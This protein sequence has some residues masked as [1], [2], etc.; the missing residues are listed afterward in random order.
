L[1]DELRHGIGC[2]LADLAV[3]PQLRFQLHLGGAKALTKL[4]TTEAVAAAEALVAQA[5][6]IAITP[7]MANLMLALNRRDIDSGEQVLFA[8]VLAQPGDHL[9]SGD[10]RAFI[11]LSQLDDV[12]AIWPSLS[13]MEELMYRVILAHEFAPVSAKIR[14]R[15][16]ADMALSMV[17]GRSEPAAQDSVIEGLDSYLSDLTDDTAGKYVIQVP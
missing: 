14:A 2:T 10:K 5:S 8:A 16:D 12:D 13:C 15:P 7:V 9:F 17:F 1:M 4:G 11:S 6:E 3:L